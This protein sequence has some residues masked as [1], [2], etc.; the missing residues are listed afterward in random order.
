MSEERVEQVFETGPQAEVSIENVHGEINF[1][2]WDEPRVR[3]EAT[4]WGEHVR[5]VLWGEGN[6]VEARTEIE[7]H[8]DGSRGWFGRERPPKVDYLVRAPR[9]THARLRNVTGPVRVGGLHGQVEVSSVDG[10][11]ELRDIEGDV[12]AQAT[13]GAVFGANLTGALHGQTTNGSITV[14]GGQLASAQAE[15]V[16][17]T[18][19]IAGLIAGCQVDARTV[20]GTLDLS[21]ADGVQA[22]VDASGLSL[23]VSISGPQTAQ[24]KGR[25]SWR[26]TVGQGQPGARVTYRTVNGRL[27]VT[28][29]DA[30]AA[31]AAASVQ[32]PLPVAE[33]PAPAGTQSAAPAAAAAAAEAPQSV[34]DILNAIERGEMTVDQAL[35]LMGKANPS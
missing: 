10:A 18:I 6:R 31:P 25:A 20:N 23:G 26:G 24:A 15:T 12:Y 33:V 9:D 30:G 17:G 1:E 3:V 14:Q 7:R 19:A 27:Q 5:V 28:G 21:L 22:D 29:A 16:N 4:W 35:T 13:N 11:V 34:M 8:D 32:T 2:A